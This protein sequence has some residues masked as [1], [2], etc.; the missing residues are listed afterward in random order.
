[1]TLSIIEEC[2]YAVSF[3]LIVMYGECHKLALYAECNYI[4]CRCAERHYPECRGASLP[5]LIL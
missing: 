4:E 5:A 3:F 2:C 1:M